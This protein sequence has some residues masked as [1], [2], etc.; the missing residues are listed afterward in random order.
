MAFRDP[1]DAQDNIIDLEKFRGR[2]KPGP[3]V[4][5]FVR[6][7]F[8]RKVLLPLLAVV[9]G[10][11]LFIFFCFT[12]VGP[13]EYGIKVVRVPVLGARGVHKEVYQTGFHFVLKPFDCEEMYRFPKDLQVLD[14]TGA[15]EEASRAATI[16]KAAHIQTSGGFFVDV[17][18]SIL[19]KIV[20]PYLVFNRILETYGLQSL[21]QAKDG[22]EQ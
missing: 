15:R 18:A 8:F 9:I 13:N 5:R 7:D 3:E 14:L 16:S 17:D 12:Y 19:Y 20:D 10:L 21:A 6:G 1:P 2:C 4:N 22:K 11:K